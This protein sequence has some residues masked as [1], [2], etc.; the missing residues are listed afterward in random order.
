MKAIQDH[1]FEQTH[2]V[3]KEVCINFM[4]PDVTPVISTPALIMWLEMASREASRQLLQP[5]EETVGTAMDM[6]HLAPTPLGMKVTVKSRITE[7]EGRRIRFQIVAFDEVEKIAEG[8]HERARVSVSRFA[9]H[10][11]SKRSDEN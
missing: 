3:T 10:L 1:S 8:F 2:L 6:K 11:N 7:L 5:G 4:G 9:A